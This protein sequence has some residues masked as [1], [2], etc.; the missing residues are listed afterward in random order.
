MLLK[1]NCVAHMHGVAEYMA[2]HASDRD[3]DKYEMFFIGYTHDIGRI[4]PFKDHADFSS[5]LIGNYHYTQIIKYHSLTP[6]EYMNLSRVNEYAVPPE[7]I[8]L[9]E[10]DLSVDST[11]KLCGYDARLK[12]I[13]SRYGKDSKEYV[14][15]ELT[16]KWLLERGFG[17]RVIED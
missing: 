4:C 8:L 11:G 13:E 2:E 16:V 6:Y 7:L 15:S 1:D 5:T 12:D 3:L 17:K 10:A 9:W 14:D